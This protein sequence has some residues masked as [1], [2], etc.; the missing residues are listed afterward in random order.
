MSKSNKR[1]ITTEES[2]TIADFLKWFFI[3]VVVLSICS[4]MLRGCDFFGGAADV[5][6][7]TVDPRM[8]LKKYEL[9]KNLAS[10]IDKQKAD[11]IAYQE[12]LKD[13]TIDKD[14]RKQLR[15]EL[16][17]LVANHNNL[18]AQYNSD[19]AKANYAF[20]NAGKMPQSN[21]EVLPR[22]YRE[23]ILSFK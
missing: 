5:V 9:F 8:M 22:E 3:I 7:E 11:I 18:V 17:G 19:M 2:T 23:F 20:C 12:D 16:R 1:F 10:A 6:Q 13:S 21:M 14:E 4:A 15:A